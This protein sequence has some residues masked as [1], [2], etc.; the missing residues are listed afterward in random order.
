MKIIFLLLLLPILGEPVQMKATI[1]HFATLPQEP[2]SDEE[3]PKEIQCGQILV[4]GSEQFTQTELCH[5]LDG[6]S[7]YS[8]DS[9]S[10]NSVQ[11][12]VIKEYNRRGFLE[13][14]LSWNDAEKK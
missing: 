12:T 7:M 11:A 13:A 2:Q 14:A 4:R 1:H 6:V 5:L 8:L 9:E 10:R 3:T